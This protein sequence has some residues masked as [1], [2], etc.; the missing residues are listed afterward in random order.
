MTTMFLCVWSCVIIFAWMVYVKYYWTAPPYA[1]FVAFALCGLASTVPA[2]LCNMFL[3]R[4]TEF[5]V[6]AD[7]PR[8][9]FMGFYI[10][11]GLG[12]EFWK[13]AAGLTLLIC[14]PTRVRLKPVDYI[15]G[16]A[17]LGLAFAAVENLV[18]F[19]HRLKEATILGRG[20][21]PVPLHASMG[22]MHGIAVNKARR[23]RSVMPLL[24]GYSVT[25]SLHTMCDTW[26]LFLP[27]ISPRLIMGSFVGV[28]VLLCAHY[29]RR[30]PEVG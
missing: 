16:F 13:M 22:V 4:E 2:L 23:D 17:V 12:E 24:A 30:L 7:I 10:G 1:L 6:Y 14:L 3:S 8:Y 19:S 20:F 29:W 26:H 5:W 11:A 15:V 28:L 27:H 18:Y 25:A 21:I 9:S